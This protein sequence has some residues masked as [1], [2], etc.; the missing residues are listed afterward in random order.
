[1]KHIKHLRK[2][3]G[4]LCL[5]LLLSMTCQMIPASADQES[6]EETI[7]TLGADLKGEDRETVL[8]L[9][10]LSEDD[11]S[12]CTVLEITNADEHNYLDKYL[13][14]QVIGKRALSSIRLNKANKGNGIQV[15]THNINYCTE[16]MYVNALATAGVEDADVIVAGPFDISGTAALVGTM[17]AYEELTGEKISEKAKDAATNELVITG[18]LSESLSDPEKA[19]ELIGYVKNEVIAKNAA[20][21]ADIKEIVQNAAEEMNVTLSEQDVDKIVSSMKK[22]SSLDLNLD[23]IKDQAK[24]LY[25]KL[26]SLNISADQA[27]GI[28][29]KILSFF[30]RL[31]NK[32]ITLFS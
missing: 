22:I 23:Q 32:I 6:T 24:G 5:L 27:K 13:S 19:S 17:K 1:M 26:S 25:D 9:L 20:S 14:S 21:E 7:V 15:T 8:S 31:Y 18:E 3:A 11:L 30:E 2:A 10:G 12:E 16:S 29:D 28:M 4:L